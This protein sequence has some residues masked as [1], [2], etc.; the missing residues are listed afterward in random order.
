MLCTFTYGYYK[1]VGDEYVL[2]GLNTTIGAIS[3]HGLFGKKVL[4]I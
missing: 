3:R 1:N 4:Y 2:R